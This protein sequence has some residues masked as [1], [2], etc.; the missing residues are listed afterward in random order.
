[1]AALESLSVVKAVATIANQFRPKAG[2]RK[3]SICR[4]SENGNDDEMRLLAGGL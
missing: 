1:M 2:S 3:R 4:V